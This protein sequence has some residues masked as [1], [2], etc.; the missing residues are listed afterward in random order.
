MKFDND[1]ISVAEQYAEALE[2]KALECDALY[3]R[4]ENVIAGLCYT[5]ESEKLS[6]STEDK[7]LVILHKLSEPHYNAFWQTYKHQYKRNVANQ[8]N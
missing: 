7:L 2:D 3:D 1:E 6:E 4:V 8:T 5:L